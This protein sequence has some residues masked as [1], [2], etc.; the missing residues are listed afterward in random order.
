MKKALVALRDDSK[1]GSRDHQVD[2]GMPRKLVFAPSSQTNTKPEPLV[3]NVYSYST[4]VPPGSSESSSHSAADAPSVKSVAGD[5]KFNID[6]DRTRLSQ[7]AFL[8]TLLGT[9]GY[10][11]FSVVRLKYGLSFEETPRNSRYY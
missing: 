4:T 2:F 6:F 10:Y 11:T 3:A 5:F 9:A 1:T 8:A 7:Y